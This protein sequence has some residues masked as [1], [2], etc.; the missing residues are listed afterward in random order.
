MVFKS[1][2][3]DFPP[4]ASNRLSGLH[5][6]NHAPTKMRGPVSVVTSHCLI[7][8][9][10]LPEIREL[11]SLLQHTANTEPRCPRKPPTS[12]PELEFH[13]LTTPS[14]PAVAILRPSGLKQTACANPR[15]TS[16]TLRRFFPVAVSQI[17]TLWSRLAVAK[18]W[19]SA[20]KA[21]EGR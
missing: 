15:W 13:T 3:P 4:T 21:I 17:R 11:P 5:A 2:F 1:P 8:R 9:S 14:S 6:A 16:E 18:R 19:L 7:V 20:L 12:V 10:R